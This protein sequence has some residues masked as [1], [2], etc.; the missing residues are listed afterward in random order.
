MAAGRSGPEGI[1]IGVY[2]NAFVPQRADAQANRSFTE[3]RPD[4][5]PSGYSAWVKDWQNR[6]AR[7]VGGCC[8]IGP[9]L[10]AEMRRRLP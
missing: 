4:L 1:A 3:I 6:G 10:I 5:T 8:G 2:A 7:I 9:E